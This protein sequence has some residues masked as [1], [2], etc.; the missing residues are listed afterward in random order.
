[1]PDSEAQSRRTSNWLLGYANSWSSGRYIDASQEWILYQEVGSKQRSST[2]LTTIL[3]DIYYNPID[4][5]LNYLFKARRLYSL[6]TQ[7]N[8]YYENERLLST[9]ALKG[10]RIGKFLTT[11]NDVFVLFFE[12]AFIISSIILLAKGVIPV[13][14]WQALL[15][16]ACMSILLLF[17]GENQPRYMYPLWFIAPMISLAYLDMWLPSARSEQWKTALNE[18]VVFIARGFLVIA[19]AFCLSYS[20]FYVLCHFSDRLCLDM[21]AWTDFRA[22]FGPVNQ[23]F[24]RKIQPESSG[25]RR[26]RLALQ[27]AHVPRAGEM[28]TV[29]HS[30]S[31]KDMHPRTFRVYVHSPYCGPDRK[32]EE[33]AFYVSVLVNGKEAERVPVDRVRNAR[34]IEVNHILPDNGRIQIELAVKASRSISSQSWQDLPPV[35]FDYAQMYK[36]EGQNLWESIIVRGFQMIK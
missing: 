8:R 24:F 21:S 18:V 17:F 31:V 23:D 1:M 25:Q 13:R 16:L 11:L 33:G 12:C 32:C 20:V 14:M 30:Y 2:A 35:Y 26:F 29:E 28:V 34:L 3:S 15:V 10:K 9:S 7:V 4:K 22:E 5:G 36:E 6:G 19:A 27:F